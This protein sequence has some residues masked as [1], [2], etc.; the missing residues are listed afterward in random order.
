MGEQ[1]EG[2]AESFG[3]HRLWSVLR[4]LSLDTSSRFAW[5]E[6][7]SAAK[8]TPPVPRVDRPALALA[9][10]TPHP[11]LAPCSEGLEVPA[12]LRGPV[13][14]SRV[15]GTSELELLALPGLLVAAALNPSFSTPFRT[16]HLCHGL[17]LSFLKLGRLPRESRPLLLP[18][19]PLSRGTKHALHFRWR[20]V[21]LVSG[22][23]GR[24]TCGRACDRLSSPASA[25][26]QDR[27]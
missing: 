9:M 6:R 14:A 16:H 11:H 21:R 25:S 2:A 10:E 27:R 19:D 23:K 20:H 22:I 4:P 26:R 12:D 5:R 3:T 17:F 13:A 15:A 24:A 8:S 18:V 1:R 7:R